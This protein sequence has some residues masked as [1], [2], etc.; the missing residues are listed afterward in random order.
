MVNVRAKARTYQPVP[1]GLYLQP[2]P[3]GVYLPPRTYR[4]PI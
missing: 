4:R 3:T 2:V 1:T